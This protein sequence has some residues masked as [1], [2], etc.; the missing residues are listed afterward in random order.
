MKQYGYCI[1]AVQGF[2]KSIALSTSHSL[3]DTLRLLTLWF[4]HGQGPEVNDA[5]IEGLKTIQIDNWLQ[6]SNGLQCVGVC[7]QHFEGMPLTL[8]ENS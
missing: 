2:F 8:T 1:A 3:Q 6:V 4:D 5:L 7:S